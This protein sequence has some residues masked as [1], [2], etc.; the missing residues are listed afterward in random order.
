MLFLL[1]FRINSMEEFKKSLN[2][3]YSIIEKIKKL[4]LKTYN[5][6]FNKKMDESIQNVKSKVINIIDQYQD[7]DD[8]VKE[9]DRNSG[10]NIIGDISGLD[11]SINQN[12]SLLLNRPSEIDAL[13]AS[14][15]VVSEI[16]SQE[17]FMVKREEKLQDIKV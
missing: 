5:D 10:V 1:I 17:Q 4:L 2:S 16:Q 12:Q 15:L 14:L 7:Y 9:K 6:D 11:T 13:R 3:M 8:A